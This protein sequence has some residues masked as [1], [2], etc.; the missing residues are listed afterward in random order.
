MDTQ[1]AEPTAVASNRMMQILATLKAIGFDERHCGE[2][3]GRIQSLPDFSGLHVAKPHFR[4]SSDPLDLAIALFLFN[5][6]IP[7]G[8]LHE[9][10][11]ESELDALKA[12]SLVRVHQE[13]GFSPLNLLP[14]CGNYITTDCTSMPVQ[15]GFLKSKRAFPIQ[16]PVM[17]LYPESYIMAGLVDRTSR[18]HAALDLGTGS[19]I[20]ALLASRQC[21]EAIGVDINPR[22]IAFSRFNQQLNGCGNL[23]YFLGDLYA[24]VAGR[25]F[26]LILSNPPYNPTPHVPAGTNFWSGG[27]SGEDILGRIIH[28]LDEHITESGICH[29]I[30]LL[31]HNKS[32]PNYREKL[33]SWLVGGLNRYDVMAQVMPNDYYFLDADTEAH[34][35]FLRENFVRFEFGVISVRRSYGSSGFYYHGPPHSMPPFFDENGRFLSPVSHFAFDAYRDQGAA[36][37]RA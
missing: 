36:C 25:R 3:L 26:D 1:I 22:A 10:F 35:G 15:T 32:G 19:G 7:L 18:L 24:P 4:M 11:G 2:R 37:S 23:E 30:T 8:K 5:E 17:W 28:G 27:T 9:L 31:C 13:V 14:C 29:I 12:M 6:E 34:Q 16:N 20:H 21:E 33:D